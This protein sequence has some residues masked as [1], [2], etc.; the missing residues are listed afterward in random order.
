MFLFL[1]KIILILLFSIQNV[2]ETAQTLRVIKALIKRIT[3]RVV[4]NQ[5]KKFYFASTISNVWPIGSLLI[6]T[7]DSLG[8]FQYDRY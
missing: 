6:I 5:K 2:R 1:T 8:I 4:L 3:K 7:F